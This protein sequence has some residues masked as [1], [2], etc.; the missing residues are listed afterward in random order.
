MQAEAEARA[1]PDDHFAGVIP[2]LCFAFRCDAPVPGVLLT[3][4]SLS[5]EHITP[6]DFATH[7]VDRL[8][9]LIGHDVTC[10]RA[11]IAIG[12]VDGADHPSITEYGSGLQVIPGNTL[13]SHGHEPGCL[14]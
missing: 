10:A 8:P 12:I 6:G 2:L 3:R 14:R 11:I 13:A 5:V 7:P 4:C 1:D 9:A